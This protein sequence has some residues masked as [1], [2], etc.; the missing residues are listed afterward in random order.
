MKKAIFFFTLFLIEGAIFGQSKTISIDSTEILNIGGIKQVI[1]IKG[2]DTS[3]PVLLY[4]HGAGGN[5]SSVI[6]K[7]DKLT[8]TLREHFIVVL[9]DQ[10]DYGKTY[11]LNKSTQPITVKL[12]VDDTKE[13]IDY[14]LNKFERK[15]LYLAGHSM[16]SVIGIHIADKYPGLLYGLV[17]M[18]PPV[19][20]KESQRIALDNLKRYFGK[21]NNQRAVK[22]L[23]AIKLPATD[24]EPLF[25]QYRWQSEYEGEKVTDEQVEEARPILKKWMETSGALSN[26]IFEMNFAEK[27]PSLKCPVYFFTGRKD[28]STNSS[29]TEKY[30]KKL[31][32]PKKKLFWFEKSAHGLPDTEPDLMQEI[33]INKVLADTYAPAGVKR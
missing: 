11:E 10:R 18:S 32:A 33:I 6:S 17:E 8:S 21:I 9:W 22:E 12:M 2:N 3:K 7:A 19:N 30:Y 1:N 27:F 29:L 26:E 23:A 14:L 4:L 16:G 20:G 31:K 25:V 28:F 5:S 24:F 15:K 13:I